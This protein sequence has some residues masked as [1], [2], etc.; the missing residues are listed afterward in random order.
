MKIPAD[1]GDQE[2][3]G[4]R[5]EE[6]PVGSPPISLTRLLPPLQL[7][8]GVG[9]SLDGRSMI[10]AALG[11]VLLWAGWTGLDAAFG[12]SRFGPMVGPDLARSASLEGA[13]PWAQGGQPARPFQVIA[14]PFLGLFAI[15]AGFRTSCHSALAAIWCVGVWG[16]VGGAIARVAALRLARGERLGISS[17]FRFAITRSVALVGAPLSPLIGIGFFA[18]LC[19]IMGL[20][21][22][23]PGPAGTT[24]AGVFTFLPLLAGLVMSLIL[25][26]MALG[27]PLMVATVSIEGE[28]AFDAL[29][30]AYSYVYQRPA[31]YAL[32]AAIAWA[33]GWAGSFVVGGLCRLDPP[34]GPVG[35]GL[36]APAQRVVSLYH[37]GNPM[38]DA[39][40]A[41]HWFWVSVVRWVAHAWLYSYFWTAATMIYLLLRHDV[42]GAPF[43]DVAG[44]DESEEA[45]VPDPPRPEDVGAGKTEAPVGDRP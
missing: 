4:D 21:Y 33:A 31:Q 18:A 34:H 20:L 30:R 29:S 17:A 24:I 14:S 32:Y 37:A 35:I 44:A 43:H 23:I 7:F 2:G 22:R 8:R 27:W 3:K 42:D 36:R 13:I 12:A 38:Q 26:G 40:T 28:D 16:I 39:P 25:V 5:M 11:L 41:I 19:A 1:V 6:E 9:V 10:L 15:D 45:F